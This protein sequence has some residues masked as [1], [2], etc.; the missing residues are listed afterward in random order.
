MDIA[1][2]HR[3]LLPVLGATSVPLGPLLKASPDFAVQTW[4]SLISDGHKVIMLPAR[5]SPFRVGDELPAD[6]FL[7]FGEATGLGNVLVVETLQWLSAATRDAFDKLTAL[8]PGAAF[9]KEPEPPPQPR[10]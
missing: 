7:A 4:S 2:K 8:R 6:W 5:L 3:A 1:D 10:S 9:P